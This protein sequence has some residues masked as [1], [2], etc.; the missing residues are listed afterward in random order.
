[1]TEPI[2]VLFIEDNPGDARLVREELRSADSKI[3]IRLEWVDRLDRGLEQIAS[4]QTDAVLLDLNLPD[5]EGLGTLARVI[6]FAPGIPVIVMTGQADE[7]LAL[8]AVQAGA[9]DYLIKG[10]V[11]GRLLTRSIQYAIQRTQAEEA[12]RES[13]E[14]LSRMIGSAMD[15]IITIDEEQRIALFNPAAEQ[16]FRCSAADVL[17]K[18]LDRL[19]P[20]GVHSFHREHVRIFGETQMTRRSMGGLSPLSGLRAD[21]EEFPIEA[22]ISQLESRGQKFYTVIL[23]DITERKQTEAKLKESEERYRGLAENFPNGTVTI[24][25]RDLRIVA[26]SGGELSKLGRS[27]A[28]FIGKHF[29]EVA[30]KE[31]WVTAEPHLRAALGGKTGTYE[32]PYF[33]ER[34]YYVLTAPLRS[35]DEIVHEIMT[36]AINIT[37]RR[38][39]EEQI[40]RQID[41]L[42]GLRAIDV[43][44]SSSFDLHVTLDLI[45]GQVLALLKVDAAAILLINSQEQS[46]EH[47]A[48]RGFRSTA[49]QHTQLKLG[50]GYAGRAVLA[51][52]TIHI[53]DLLDAGGRLSSSLVWKN[54]S[55]LD[56]YGIPLIVK[57]HVK[58][59]LEIYHR[60]PFE[61]NPEWLD[62]L[63]SLAGQAAIAIDNAQLFDSLQRSNADLEKRVAERTHELNKANVELEHANRAKDEFLANMS[64]ELRTPLNS[65]LGLSE[66]LL[67]QRRDPLS[68]HQ[69]RSIQIV[70]SS[71]NHLLELI[72]DILDLSKIEAGKFDY[73]PQSLSVDE[74]CRSSLAFVKTQSVKKSITLTY[75]NEASIPRIYA[76]PRRLKQILVNLLMNAVKFTP[77]NGQVILQINTDVEQDIIR[78]SVI[79]TGIG[80]APEDLPRLFQPFVQLD[81]SLNRQH[82]GTGLGLALV[83][84]L[85]DLHGGSVHVESEIGK[86]SRFSIILSSKQDEISKIENPPSHNPFPAAAPL[87]KAGISSEVSPLKGVILLAED[88]LAN[89]L[90]IGEYLEG[91]G[92]EVVTAHDGVEAVEKA[93][94]LSPDLILMDIQMPVLSGLDA[95]SRL[96]GNAR[97]TSTPIIALTALAMPGD[98]EKC[99][100]AGASEY[101]SKPVSLKKLRQTIETIL[102]SRS[103]L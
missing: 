37:E 30:S 102:N 100:L 65:I 21:G 96:R 70:Q 98:R 6:S 60:S 3:V 42:N 72:N 43:A 68:E 24:Y 93:D 2:H 33:D 57:G 50:E 79:D 7:A 73:H 25:D 94:A 84:R 35:T 4:K 5:S 80:I 58:G 40:Q 45:L 26:V 66:T 52:K 74:I 8:Q 71:G 31:T 97:F 32:T 87:D 69:Q 46:I 27:A 10:Q 101:M 22:S 78:F 20:E 82:D 47:A 15:A 44:I 14:R 59:V 34:Q 36:A 92:Y 48:S 9:Q 39:A 61:S 90:T 55:F 95:I 23:R 12:L 81:S 51:R 56:Y 64:H 76:D 38:R 62:F 11:D 99:L 19:L 91:Y 85:T 77:E 53:P 63:E 89:I 75:S 29:T 18:P 28:E 41:R 88:N 1:V 13:E 16:M 17:G 54:E 86:G 67:E 49:L 83:Q 103:G